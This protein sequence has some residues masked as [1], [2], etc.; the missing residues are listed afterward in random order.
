MG[1]LKAHCNNWILEKLINIKS[2]LSFFAVQLSILFK[3]Q[4]KYQVVYAQILY[5]TIGRVPENG[6]EVQH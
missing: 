1:R 4:C 3:C 5:D 2:S 6:R